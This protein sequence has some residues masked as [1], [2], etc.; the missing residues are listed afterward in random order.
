MRFRHLLV[1]ALIGCGF[2]YAQVEGLEARS[3]DI[4]GTVVEYF[5]VVPDGF[6]PG[7]TYPVLL[8]FPP[9]PAAVH[10]IT[11]LDVRWHDASARGWVVVSPLAP[12]DPVLRIEVSGFR[13]SEALIP[14]LLD[15]VAE[16]VTFEGGQAH[17]A[18]AA[19]GGKGALRIATLFPER[20]RSVLVLGGYAE[21][22]DFERIS[23][24]EE[25]P[26]R[27]YVGE[28]DVEHVE[29]ITTTYEAMEAASVA[30]ELVVVDGDG[31]RLP[32]L[33]GTELFDWLDE[34]RP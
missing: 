31:H 8:L 16:D 24:L 30:A 4:D 29:R 11:E 20:F 34:Q 6:T 14:P 17:L 27:L 5:C 23:A 28:N 22:V 15:H 3:V 9:G 32:S 13:G 12:I 10:A 26:V 21:D 7:G 1:L 33:G 19:S 25:A 18:G 2:A